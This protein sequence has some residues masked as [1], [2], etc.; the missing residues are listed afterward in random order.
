MPSHRREEQLIRCVKL[1]WIKTHAGHALN[2]K[3]DELA[4]LGTRSQTRFY[5]NRPT[6]NYNTE[7]LKTAQAKWEDRWKTEQTCRQTRQMVP[8]RN[9]V[10][11]KFL[12]SENRVN[13]SLLVQFITGHNY[14][15]YHRHLIAPVIDK[16][17]RLCSKETEDS[18]HLLTECEP[19]TWSRLETLLDDKPKKLPHPKV[20]L[21]YIRTTKIVNLM[22]PP[23]T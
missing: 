7:L 2:K 8:E 22:E 11:T 4:K 5:V 9:T 6:K 16:T 3:A 12:F 21:K 18:W 1:H 19:L 13:S 20:T 14:L 10:L 23:P 15:N 17:C